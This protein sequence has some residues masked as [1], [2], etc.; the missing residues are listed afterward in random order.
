MKKLISIVIALAMILSLSVTALAAGEVDTPNVKFTVN[1]TNAN[2]GA[3]SETFTFSPFTIDTVTDA[4]TGI[5]TANAPTITTI[6]PVTVAAGGSA[7]VT[8]ALPAVTAFPSVG[9][10]TY[11]FYQTVGTTAGVTYYK[12]GA[13]QD[14]SLVVTIVE[15]TDGQLRVGALHVEA[16]ATTADKTGAIT[17]AYNC[18]K[19]KVTKTVTGNL[20]DKTKKFDFT[21]TFTAPAN[22]TVN[23]VI[24]YGDQTIAAGWTGE[25]SVTFQLANGENIQFE[26]IP[27]DVTY[28]VAETAVDGYTTTKTNDSG[29]IAAGSDITSAFTNDKDVP[30]DTGVILESLPYVVIGLV[31]VAAV[32]FMIVRKNRKVED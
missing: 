24:S 12:D 32:V 1:F 23:S 16:G 25:K 13:Q 9:V 19:L 11:K 6:A 21:V 4:A 31:V 30:V 22:T 8:I 27:K 29:A 18:G 15:G 3:L 14:M 28:V 17:N 26:N 2:S 20:G 5:T 10:Y 7:E